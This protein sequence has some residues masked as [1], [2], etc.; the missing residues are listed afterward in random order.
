MSNE[1]WEWKYELYISSKNIVQSHKV[2]NRK[3]MEVKV[4]QLGADAT[5]L[6]K[7]ILRII[8]LWIAYIYIQT[9]YAW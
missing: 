3:G 9:H 1:I 8:A 4:G 5:F 2:R 7:F 6:F